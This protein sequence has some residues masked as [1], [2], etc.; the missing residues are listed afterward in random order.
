MDRQRPFDSEIER[1]YAKHHQELLRF[2]TGM[3]G[4]RQSAADLVQI[5]FTKLVE[6]IDQL[7]HNDLR[8]WLFKVAVNEARSH[9]RRVSIGKK[10]IRRIIEIKVSE[11]KLPAD[12]WSLVED[13]SASSASSPGFAPPNFSEDCAESRLEREE[14]AAKALSSL[15]GDQR[16]VVE[17]RIYR[18]Q[19]FAEIAEELE[20]PIG[21]VLTRMRLALAK[22]KQILREHS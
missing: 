4:D 9:G 21:T 6:T 18:D 14:L 2:L 13:A 12:V 11:G 3:L 1:L 10:S 16:E 5:V 22:L 19:K 8:A 17:R 20:L 7:E 15:P